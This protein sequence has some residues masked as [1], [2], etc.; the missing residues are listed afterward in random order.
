VTV[1]VW[2][3][4]PEPEMVTIAERTDVEEFPVAVTVI[5]PLF[6]PFAIDKVS[7]V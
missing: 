4:T 3:D 5:V 2:S 1:T 7:Q 6:E